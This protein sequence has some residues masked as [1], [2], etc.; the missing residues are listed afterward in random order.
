M[1]GSQEGNEQ[2]ENPWNGM[3]EDGRASRP[4]LGDQ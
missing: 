3:T 1:R 4:R 2:V